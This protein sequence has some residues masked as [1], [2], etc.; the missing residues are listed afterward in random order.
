MGQMERLIMRGALQ[1]EFSVERIPGPLAMS[2]RHNVDINVAETENQ[3]P[4]TNS[5]PDTGPG[6]CSS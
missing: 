2:P 5:L 6:G 1:L 3:T 4:W